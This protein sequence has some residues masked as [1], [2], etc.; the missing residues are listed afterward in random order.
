MIAH[1]IIYQS[2]YDYVL[3]RKVQEREK[4][5]SVGQNGSVIYWKD[6]RK[7][8]RKSTKEKMIIFSPVQVIVL[9][10]LLSENISPTSFI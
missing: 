7:H 2:E 8:K 9:A 6:M 3:K 10:D 5:K 1:R 4:K